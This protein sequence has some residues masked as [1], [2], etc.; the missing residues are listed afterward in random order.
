MTPGHWW[1]APRG[2]KVRSMQTT[3]RA[4][5]ARGPCAAPGVHVTVDR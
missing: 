5:E 2:A 1:D 3:D 4:I